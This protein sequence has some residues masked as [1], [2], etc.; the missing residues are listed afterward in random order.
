MSVVGYDVGCESSVI[1]VARN[2]GIEV[3]QND[4]GSRKTASMVAFGDGQR[5]FGNDAIA[6]YMSNPKNSVINFKRFLGR[7]MADPELALERPYSSVEVVEHPDMPNVPAFKVKYNGADKF[8]TPEQLMGSMLTKLKQSTEN[9][10]DGSR[11]ND[12]VLACP[13]YW[14]DVQRRALLD[15]ANVAGLNVL[16]LLNETTAV[17]LNYG[18]LR[19]LPEKEANV[20]CFFDMGETAT[21][22]SVVSFVKGQLSVLA[23]ACDRNLGGRDLDQMLVTHFAKMIK[24]K[25]KLDVYTNPKA[26]IKMYKECKRVKHILSANTMVPFNIEYLMNDTDVTGQIERSEFEEL[27]KATILSRV[28]TP[29]TTALE[30]AGK[31]KEDV[32]SLEIIGGAARIPAVQQQLHE[33]FGKELSK[34]CD[35]DES[36]ARGCA[37]MC[38]MM[39]PNCRVR[40]FAVRDIS[41]YAIEIQ[42]GPAPSNGMATDGSRDAD[43]EE[44]S[45][46]V[47]FTRGNIIPSTKMIS[48]KESSEPFQIIARY[49]EPALLPPGTE[50]LL[51][52]F[53]VSGMPPKPADE[54]EKPPKIK[55]KM[56]LSLHGILNISNAQM[57]EEYEVEETP[58]EAKAAA[59]AAA[60]EAKAEADAKA[61]ADAAAAEAAADVSKGDAADA[62]A[63]GDKQDEAEK[64]DTEKPAD[65][66][67]AADADKKDD[68]ETMDTDKPADDAADADKKDDAAM[69]TSAEE[70]PAKKKKKKIRRSDLKVVTFTSGGLNEPNLQKLFESELEM[71]TADRVVFETNE[72]R[73]ALES[74]ALEMRSKVQGELADYVPQDV[75]DAFCAELT[76]LEDWLYD[77]GEEAQKSEVRAKLDAATKKGD[78]FLYRQHEAE[79]RDEAMGELKKTIGK[80]Q[81]LATSEDEKYAHI[82]PE[83]RQTVTDACTA[84]D[85]WLSEEQ[86]KQAATAK[87]A[88]PVLTLEM[89][90]KKSTEL[91]K[92]CKPVMNK[93]KPKP[94]PVETPKEEEKPDADAAKDGDAADKKD[95]DA[96]MD[97]S[98]DK[99]AEPAADAMD[100]DKDGDEKPADDAD[101]DKTMAD[102]SDD[103]AAAI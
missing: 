41:P 97:T 25:Y 29:L 65:D 92:T 58:E 84:A 96:A 27:A 83:E 51:G 17:A 6:Q 81:G 101:G 20:V 53:I 77:D 19:P 14:T 78:V 34:T 55:V 71:A 18:I 64:M 38:A 43:S 56:K 31:T 30:L 80:W 45:Q 91:S 3:L 67:A 68:A 100:T 16:Q 7:T 49:H 36:V 99:P 76:A 89:L 15:S 95:G 73:N 48:F 90:R 88:D 32:H 52:R 39:S 5:Y 98:E 79:H 70:E 28:L 103:K 1:S 69:D 12:C 62:S 85:S 66:A 93:P 26:M 2:G 13:A 11:V 74:Y 86:T 42:W 82:T 35:S 59:D 33:W 8:L 54:N 61:K 57:L 60:K 46:T 63:D 50:P 87:S 37:L 102:A 94:K 24:E 22:V 44:N 21:N 9:S 47:L 23:T 40:A 10:L 4:I 72:A 75:S